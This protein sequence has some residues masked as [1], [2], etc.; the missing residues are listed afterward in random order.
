MR[1]DLSS[2][3]TIGGEKIWVVGWWW[4]RWRRLWHASYGGAGSN[5]ALIVV[6]FILLIIVL[7]LLFDVKNLKHD[8]FEFLIVKYYQK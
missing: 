1:L 2:S 6:L 3:N 5:F 4:L 7:S 8:S